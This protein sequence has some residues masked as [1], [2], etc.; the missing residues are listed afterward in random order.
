MIMAT[1]W[2][3]GENDGMGQREIIH[4]ERDGDSR[5]NGSV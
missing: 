4:D 1:V 5:W 2:R 3:D